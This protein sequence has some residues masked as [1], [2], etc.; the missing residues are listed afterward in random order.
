MKTLNFYPGPSKIY[1]EVKHWLVA[2]YDSG[3]LARNH[4]SSVF[5]AFLEETIALLKEKLDIPNDY[6]VYFTSSA[7][8][9]WE[10]VNQSLLM[11]QVHFFYNGAFGK[12][13]FR[14]AVTNQHKEPAPK[15][16]SIRGSR[17]KV[18][19]YIEN[20]EMEAIDSLCFVQNE[21]SN[22]T[23]VSNQSIRVLRERFPEALIAVDA[24]SSMAGV[25]LDWQAGDVW[26]ASVQ[27]CFGLPSGLAVMVVSPKAIE[28]AFQL[29][30][31]NHYNSFLTIRA[32]F[33]TNQTPYTPN[34]LGIFLLNQWSKFVRPIAEI[35]IETLRK[36]ERLLSFIQQ[37]KLVALVKN[38]AVQSATVLAIEG[39]EQVISTIKEK[40]N[41][42]GIILGNGYGEWQNTTFRI[43]NFPAITL[44]EMEELMQF[45]KISEATF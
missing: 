31:L 5:L 42:E 2:A 10:I 7:T 41:Q 37:S 11:G 6:E 22:G 16:F 14:Y 20:C 3:L 35:E 13:W 23:Q 29:N 40:A 33:I 24:T 12:K 19:D 8:E 38:E 44:E 43:A 26:F 39:D 36:K 21:T 17:Y 34:T 25:Q 30:E 32:N 9:C 27:K 28:R 1:P 45:L 18:D 15:T 4:R